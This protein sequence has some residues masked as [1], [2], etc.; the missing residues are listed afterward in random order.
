MQLKSSETGRL[1]SGAVAVTSSDLV[2]TG[3]HSD[4]EAGRHG[5]GVPRLLQHHLV[6]PHHHLRLLP[7]EGSLLCCG[8]PEL[9]VVINA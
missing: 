7:V 4:H 2:E 8:T 9:D 6:P 1:D 5:D 3:Q